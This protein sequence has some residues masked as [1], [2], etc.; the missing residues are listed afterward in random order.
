VGDQVR[1]GR[2]SDWV[3]AQRAEPMS[4][5][6][7][8]TLPGLQGPG[9]V[10]GSH[11]VASALR[12]GDLR[13]VGQLLA[14]YLLVEAKDGL[15]LV[16]Q[17]AAHERVLYE[18]L[19]RQG[20]EQGVE[21]QGLLIPVTVELGPLAAAALEENGELVARLGF[22]VEAFG[23][24]SV[25]VRGLPVLLA[26]QDPASLLRSLA[27]EL[28]SGPGSTG[29]GKGDESRLL[30][31][32]DRIFATL[33]CHSARRAGDHLDPREQQQILAEVDTIPWAPTCPHGRP[34]AVSYG[35]AD[36]ERRF[37]RR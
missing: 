29:T 8:Q 13:L 24:A 34:V 11:E 14:A 1:D 19:R 17:H 3:F 37:R 27:A 30:P 7:A 15:L 32:M 6:G 12:F 18:R 21:R 33:A 20:L 31:A 9:E 26:G 22:E 10:E 4:E 25:V 36:I 35:M 5:S 28:E 23:D 2:S 16:D